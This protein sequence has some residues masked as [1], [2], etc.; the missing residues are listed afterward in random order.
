MTEAS[1]ELEQLRRRERAV[2]EQLAARDAELAEALDRQQA[3]TDVLDAVA[4][5][6]T[7][8]QPVFDA[9]ARHAYRLVGHGTASLLVKRDGGLV[10]VSFE[11]S[12]VTRA[13]LGAHPQLEEAGLGRVLPLT[14]GVGPHADA[15][16][17]GE[18]VHLPDMVS[19]AER[20]PDFVTLWSVMQSGVVLPLMRH[21]EA[22]GAL[23][24]SWAIGGA[25]T[26]AEVGLL[27]VFANQAAIAVDNARLL[28][29][30]E[31]RNTDLAESLELQTATSEVLRLISAHPGDLDTV[32]AGILAKAAELCDADAGVVMV[33][34]GDLVRC[35]A[36]LGP[37][38]EMALR[39]QAIHPARVTLDA[40]AS[41]SPVLLDDP[42]SSRT[43][44]CW[45]RSRGQHPQLRERAAVPRRRVDR[46]HQPVAVRGSA[47]RSR[48]RRRAAVVRRACGDRD[49]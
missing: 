39:G 14:P 20:Y 45:H 4:T 46:Q 28:N 41:R 43:I 8:L 21:G 2:V 22:I 3:M 10:R 5:A 33:R 16:L 34:H 36:A 48:A 1:D 18:I 31:A 29:D 49:R 37:F 27:Q 25:Y 24:F 35:E 6:R 23:A 12:E 40:C 15:V 19:A 44:R 32:L 26:E 13:A 42:S 11:A 30:I 47:V 38:A 17:T 9:I 7:D